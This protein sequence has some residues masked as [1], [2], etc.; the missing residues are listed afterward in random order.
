MYSNNYNGWPGAYLVLGPIDTRTTWNELAA[1][2]RGEAVSVVID[3]KQQNR[4]YQN[5]Q[6]IQ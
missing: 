2:T 1:Y 4:K 6:M 5:E 3:S